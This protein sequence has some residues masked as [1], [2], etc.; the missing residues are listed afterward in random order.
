MLGSP[1][2]ATTKQGTSCRATALPGGS[3]CWA[4]SPKVR[5]QRLEARRR[6]GHEKAS[7]ARAL[8]TWTRAGR[9]MP[10]DDLPAMLLGA[11]SAVADGELEP[12]Q[13]TA[14]SALVRTSLQVSAHLEWGRRLA[15]VETL[16][17]RLDDGR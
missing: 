11:A 17:S 1:C 8:K 4:H 6:G 5:E 2:Q 3:L 13:A 16:L 15:E 14:I 9:H 12:A 7:S 10:V